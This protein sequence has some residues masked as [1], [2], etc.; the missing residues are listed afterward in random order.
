[1]RASGKSVL[2]IS[3]GSLGPMRHSKYEYIYLIIAIGSNVPTMSDDNPTPGPASQ[4]VD[5]DVPKDL[6]RQIQDYL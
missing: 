2:P 5:L 3:R 4:D 1:M 6:H